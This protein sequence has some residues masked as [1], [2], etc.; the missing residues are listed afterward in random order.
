MYCISKRRPR[1]IRQKRTAT[2]TQARLQAETPKGG[3]M[4][5]IG[6]SHR[7]G[8]VSSSPRKRHC[9]NLIRPTARCARSSSQCLV[10]ALER[11]QPSTSFSIRAR[12]LVVNPPTSTRTPASPRSHP[13]RTA[14][15]RRGSASAVGRWRPNTVGEPRAERAAHVPRY[16]DPMRPRTPGS[17]SWRLPDWVRESPLRSR[18]TY[19]LR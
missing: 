15:A 18:R 6:T 14:A 2:E 5:A 9:D 12:H 4:Q 19:A 17:G 8:C 16:S 11:G 3:A 7:P 13:A 1:R 10:P